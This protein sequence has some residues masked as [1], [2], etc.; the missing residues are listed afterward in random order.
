[1]QLRRYEGISRMELSEGRKKDFR[2]LGL[3]ARAEGH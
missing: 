3:A 1:M 2:R